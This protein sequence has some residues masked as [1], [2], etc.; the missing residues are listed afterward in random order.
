MNPTTKGTLWAVAA[1]VTGSWLPVFYLFT[2]VSNDPFVWRSW[3]LA[4][5]V[6]A[7]LPAFAF[8]PAENKVWRDKARRL[9]LYWGDTGEPEPVKR[10]WQVVRT[11]ALWMVLSFTL[12]LAFWVWAATL[13]DP[14]VVT[15]IYQLMLIGMVWLASRL[16]RK[17]STGLRTSPH[18]IGGKHWTLMILSFVG[19]ALVIWSET[20]EVRTLNWL[21]IVI[22]LI[23]TATATGSLWGTVST[24]RL[25]GWPGRNPHD[26]VWNATFAAV[27]GRVG[28]LPL[29]LLGSLLFF[30][31][32][33]NG[34]H[35]T[36]TVV[37]L[38]SLTG[39]FNA[40]GALSH[41]Y[42][43]YVTSSLSVQRIMF[44]SPVLQML[45]LWLFA[46]V[47]IANPQGLLIGT[48]I[49]LLANV[50]WQAKAA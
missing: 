24:G 10:L 50:G 11:P 23:G 39:V 45:W 36:W 15:I 3:L 38:L 2:H 43:L 20:G 16:G 18:I 37:G 32:D 29:T 40:V 30:P 46:D 19:A 47:S 35:L 8:I 41:R 21:G 14:L 42:S 5:Q 44:F 48:A 12:D 17:I 13:I 34:Y 1:V 33:G 7:L 31:P 4:F 9:L 26:L 49:V 27:A 25:M 22:A 28:A 6:V